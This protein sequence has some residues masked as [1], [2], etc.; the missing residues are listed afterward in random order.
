MA[1]P[2][3]SRPLRWSQLSVP[4]ASRLHW[5]E[6]P[7]RW[8]VEGSGE[9]ER[10][11]LEPQAA[12]DFW[13]RTHYGFQADNGHALLAEVTGDV[14]VTTC[15]R[16]FP[17]HQYD[18]AGL[19]LRLSPSC[20]LKTSVEYEP[21]RAGRL[22]AVVTNH[23]YSDWSTAPFEGDGVWLRVRRE[24]ADYIVD[25][26]RDGQA[27]EQLRMAHLAEDDGQ[28]SVACGLYAC[29]PKGAGF[30]AEFSRLEIRAGRL[31]P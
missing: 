3:M 19:M 29:S 17:V 28:R 22:G 27:W 20:W 23:G 14:V 8:S 26:S 5:H 13:Q 30:A 15:V 24:G 9:D 4:A 16:F 25:A 10:L 6:E 7:A 12:T 1:S 21:G 11:R 2:D 18:Q 31:A